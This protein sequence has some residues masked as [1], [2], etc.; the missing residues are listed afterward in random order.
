MKFTTAIR[1]NVRRRLEAIEEADI[2][3]GIPAY[4]NSHTVTNVVQTVS[5]GLHKYF[6]GK[7]NIIIVADG[8]SVDDTR[9]GAEEAVIEPWIEKL[10]YIYRGIAGKGSALRAIFESA[11]LLS[12]K[13]CVVC[14][15]DLR[16]ITPQWIKNL[17]Q[18]IYDG[19]EFVTP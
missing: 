11:H 1:D 10:V 5:Q 2:V 18:P 7:K 14:D 8:G 12:A 16:S 6:P 19:Y 15:S 3:V 4:N 17:V 13:V 9:E